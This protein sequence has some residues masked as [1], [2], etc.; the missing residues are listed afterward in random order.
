MKATPT[1]ASSQRR[2]TTVQPDVVKDLVYRT[3]SA[4]AVPVHIADDATLRA[5]AVI[6]ERVRGAGGER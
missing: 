5:V 6:L 2:V 1:R 4:Q 3:T